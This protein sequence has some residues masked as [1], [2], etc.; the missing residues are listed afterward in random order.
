MAPKGR[1][2]ESIPNA[3]ER[4]SA[5]IDARSH[6]GLKEIPTVAEK[7]LAVRYQIGDA[8]RDAGSSPSIN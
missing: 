2:I 7:S 6:T 1:Q 8:R 5:L 4:K 3:N